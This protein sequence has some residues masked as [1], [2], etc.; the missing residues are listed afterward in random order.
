M[1][2]FYLLSSFIALWMM[3]FPLNAT[4]NYETTVNN[5]EAFSQPVAA[6]SETQLQQF[7]R[8]RRLFQQ[9]WVISP[10]IDE[11]NAQI[12]GL[13]P[14]YNR[15]S[16]AA[17]HPKNGR[18]QP[19][20]PPDQEM[21]SMLVRL[22]VPGKT[23]QGAPNP[24]PA[25]GDQL[26]EQGIPNVPGE[27]RAQ[28]DYEEIS[29]TLADGEVVKLQRPRLKFSDLNFGELGDETMTSARVAPAI[30]GL[31]LLE[32]VP[33]SALLSLADPEDRNQDG[34]SGRVNH[35]WD[36]ATQRTTVGRFGWKANQPTV[37]QQ[38]AGAFSGDLGIT[39]IL[40][41]TEN[42]TTVQQACRQAI[43][44]GHP[45]LSAQQLEDIKFYHFT[46]AVPARRDQNNPQVQVGEQLFNQ[47]GCP[48]CHQATLT[49][50]EF[51]TLPTLA[52]QTIHPYS[53]LLL[54]DMGEGLA[55]GRPDFEATGTEWRTTPLWGLG[56]IATVNG[57][58]QLLHD[59]RAR[60]ILE[61]IL[62][63]GGEAQAAKDAVK[64]LS[65][66]QREALL[67]FLNSL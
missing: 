44:G 1:K 55:D 39:S 27:G 2:K 35:V 22:S 33:E 42:C 37:A 45:E 10:P 11:E 62:W 21:R 16:C 66:S 63:H 20:Q 46:L 65:K 6:L 41:P 64:Q 18:G 15:L 13:G 24:H 12:D 61:A 56:L 58:T 28:V 40:F 57:H 52:Q 50:G 23:L 32:A 47:L 4:E 67:Q 29:E 5:R 25:Y 8:G 51:P 17:C 36:V 14:V 31:G 7:F 3:V 59:G 26:N 19:P 54:H 60:N 9:V 34:I 38:I 49:T 48:G 53:D 43:S 30:F